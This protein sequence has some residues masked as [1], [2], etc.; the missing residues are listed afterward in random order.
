MDRNH[1]VLGVVSGPVLAIGQATIASAITKN[2]AQ[3]AR[4]F[5]ESPHGIV[6]RHPFVSTTVMVVALLVCHPTLALERAYGEMAVGVWRRPDG[7]LCGA[8]LYM[9]PGQS[10]RPWP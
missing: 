2:I 5:S 8:R 9:L 4:K 7:C 6:E 1:S 3:N 10:P